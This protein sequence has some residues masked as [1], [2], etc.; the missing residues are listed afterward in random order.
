M[1]DSTLLTAQETTQTVGEN[2][3]DAPASAVEDVA[4]NATEPTA[5]ATDQ[6]VEKDAAK[7]EPEK[8]K[9]PSGAPEDY[10]DFTL[11]EGVQAD[12]AAIG[13]FKDIAKDLGL[14]KDQAQR[15]VDLQVQLTQKG[16]EAQ[17]DAWAQHVSGWVDE[18]KAYPEI[19]GADMPQK[20]AV[21]KT[22]VERFGDDQLRKDL[23]AL[24]IGNMPSL[25]RAFYRAGRAISEDK[26]VAGGTVMSPKD[27]A[28]VMFPTM[29]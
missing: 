28:R 3:T 7:D 1:S 16:A 6:G 11:P 4:K 14:S 13:Q 22:F 19:G 26:L 9:E 15:L 10:G 24:G 21:A 25:V 5:A 20:L 17:R 29:K 23:D 8:D 18:V 2:Q 12:E 27:P